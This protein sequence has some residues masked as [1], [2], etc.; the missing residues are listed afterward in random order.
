MPKPGDFPL[1]DP[2]VIKYPDTRGEMMEVAREARAI[3]N[4]L[5]RTGSALPALKV[6]LPVAVDRSIDNVLDNYPVLVLSFELGF[7]FAEAERKR[8]WT[9]RG[10]YDPRVWTALS[11]EA[12][13]LSEQADGN[14]MAA[15]FLTQAGFW[16]GR[17]GEL[18]LQKLTASLQNSTEL[19]IQ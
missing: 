11:L 8:G 6:L 12:G 17:Q 4:E 1:A 15:M 5:R 9:R 16:V 13:H 10:G 7:A 3:S 2:R 14:R 18:G 19:H